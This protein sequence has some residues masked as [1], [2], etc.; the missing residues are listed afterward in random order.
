MRVARWIRVALVALAVAIG[1][2]GFW[3]VPAS[4]EVRAVELPLPWPRAEPL[5]VALI[6]DLHVGS[7]YYGISRLPEIV[8]SINAAHPDV[9][10]IAGDFVTLGVIGGHQVPPEPIAAALE[11][12]RSV[13]GTYAVLGN[14]DRKFDGPRVLRALAAA[15]IHVLEDTAV[16]ISTPGGPLWLAGVSDAWTGPHDV[17]RALA[18][19]PNDGSPLLV[20]THNPDV[21]PEIPARAL[22][23]LAG[24]THGGQ[25]RL[26]LVGAPIVP[27]EFGQRYA[28]GEVIE[29]GRHLF[30]STG[31]GTS[32]IP[33]RLGVPP[34][35]FIL[36]I[37]RASD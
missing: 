33:I 6:S 13:Y 25:V 37:K 15:G 31:L 7:P 14:H 19:V 23:T 2:P 30:V 29:R 16:V 8:D 3:L 36:T 10:C 11:G 21:F 4:L 26:P 27:S 35:I 17:P 18:T 9:V 22:L 12:L 34:T 5:R 20:L 28:A 1:V 32:D 24:H